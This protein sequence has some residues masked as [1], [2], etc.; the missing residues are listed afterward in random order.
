MVLISTLVAVPLAARAEDYPARPVKVII[1]FS[2]GGP[3][4]IV[5]RVITTKMR[6]SG[7]GQPLII[8]NRGGGGGSVGTEVAARSEPDGYT[9]MIGTSSTHGTNPHLYAK[10][11]YHPV[12]SFTPI[13]QV[14]V[15]PMMLAVNPKVPARSVAEFIAYAKANPGKLNQSSAG[16]GAGG[17]ILGALLNK[18]AGITTVVVPYA[19]SGPASRD[20]IAGVTDF[21]IDGLPVL[22]PSARAGGLFLLATTMGRRAQAFPDVPTMAELGFPD[23]DASTWNVL[24]APA[25]T[26]KPIIDHIFKYVS[27]ALADAG[28]IARLQDAGV[29]PTPDTTPEKAAAFTRREFEKWGPLVKMSGAKVE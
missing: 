3:T 11:G 22:A 28:V 15:T 18:Q 7:F 10:L 1:P 2:A 29:E 13:A 12:D 17:H 26:P 6:E 16:V 25:G 23:F 4:D 21:A 19:G 27:I 14:G 5:G 8:E 20:L 9:L 24:Y